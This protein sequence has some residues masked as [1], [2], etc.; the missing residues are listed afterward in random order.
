MDLDSTVIRIAEGRKRGLEVDGNRT[1][2]PD[3]SY[4]GYLYQ[5]ELIIAGCFG[6]IF[7]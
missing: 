3:L 7:I 6:M 1:K 5:P 2:L 4:A